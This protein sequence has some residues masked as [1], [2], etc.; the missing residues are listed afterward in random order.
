[1]FS[2][3][4]DID[5]NDSGSWF[6][7][8]FNKPTAN[9]TTTPYHPDRSKPI[10]TQEKIWLQRIITQIFDS[11]DGKVFQQAYLGNLSEQSIRYSGSE[12]PPELLRE[13]AAWLECPMN[14][15]EM[16]RKF[17]GLV[18]PMKYENIEGVIADFDLIVKNT[19]EC[20]GDKDPLT[21]RARRVREDFIKRLDAG[22][23][24]ASPIEESKKRPHSDTRPLLESSDDDAQPSASKQKTSAT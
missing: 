16:R 20:A 13:R 19:V 10:K 15:Y 3:Y 14:L 4:T 11:E 6:R 21:E 2:T 22:Y 9:I 1:M 12:T 8:I 18:G 7:S 23:A 17:G 5:P 24:V